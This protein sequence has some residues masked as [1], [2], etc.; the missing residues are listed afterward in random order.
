MRGDVRMN[1]HNALKAYDQAVDVFW[2]CRMDAERAALPL[3]EFKKRMTQKEK[4]AY[5]QVA[6]E[7][8]K[9]R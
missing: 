1:L 3:D 9:E 7:L 2:N 4:R 5:Q 6:R 8:R